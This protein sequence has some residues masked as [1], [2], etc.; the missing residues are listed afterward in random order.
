MKTTP[1]SRLR[2]RGRPSIIGVAGLLLLAMSWLLWGPAPIAGAQTTTGTIV[3]ELE[4]TPNGATDVLEF[5]TSYEGSVFLADGE[6]H[7]SAALA[8]GTYSIAESLPPFW[9]RS[10]ASCDNGSNVDAI[11]V[12]AGETVT[13]QF[14]LQDDGA[15]VRVQ[16]QIDPNGFDTKVQFESDFGDFALGDLEIQDV[17]LLAGSYDVTPQLPSGWEFL[18]AVC[19]DGLV[20]LGD[21][22]PGF[23]PTFT[24]EP[25]PGGFLNC[26]VFVEAPGNP[27]LPGFFSPTG[28]VPCTA[29]P[30]GTYVDV[31][32]A[33]SPTPCDPG[34]TTVGVASASPADCVPIDTDGDGVDDDVDLCPHT[35]LDEPA[36]DRLKHNRYWTDAS[37]DFID[38]RGSSSG[39][40]ISDTAGCSASQIIDAAGLGNGHSRFG[41]SG[42]AL[43]DWV[44]AVS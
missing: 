18:A 42:S 24:V 32:G 15:S 12:A 40:T 16:A 29:A 37:G 20:L 6:S 1:T 23:D 36:P 17:R 25:T 4:V 26:T 43:R 30:V 14:W 10:S 33:T 27:C 3:L 9:Q 8:P 34:F 5:T 7:T 2:T 28:A 31:A 21:G 44:A 41:L 38:G 13:C 39:L 11:D 19:D 35:D 22:S